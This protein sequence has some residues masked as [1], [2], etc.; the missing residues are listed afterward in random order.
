M[1]RFLFMF[2]AE[3]GGDMLNKMIIY[4]VY[5]INAAS[6]V[7]QVAIVPDALSVGWQ[8]A[9]PPHLVWCFFITRAATSRS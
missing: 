4:F 9:S 1:L 7:R 6:T 5:R 2:A 8:L 3:A